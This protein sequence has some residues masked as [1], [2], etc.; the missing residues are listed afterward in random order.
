MLPFL[1]PVLFTFY[2]QSVLKFKK[3]I[4][5][6]RVNNMWRKQ[7]T[8]LKRSHTQTHTRKL[9]VTGITVPLPVSE[10]KS[11]TVF[12]LVN[13]SAPQLFQPFRTRRKAATSPARVH[14]V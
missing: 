14:G 4:R 10:F 5:C 13:Q 2:I 6:Q 12:A 11:Y 1:V 7:L 8:K 3:K 9:S